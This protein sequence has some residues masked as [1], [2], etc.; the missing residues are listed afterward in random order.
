MSQLQVGQRAEY[1]SRQT[2]EDLVSGIWEGIQNAKDW[3]IDNIFGWCSTVTD[4][5]KNFF[6]IHSPSTLFRDDIGKNLAFGVGEGFGDAMD[7]VSK[8]MQKSIW[9]SRRFF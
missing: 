7:D 5:I 2:N 4:S 9:Q 6:G 3:L 8:D 1:F